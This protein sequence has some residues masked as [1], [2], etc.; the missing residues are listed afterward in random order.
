MK[1]IIIA[2]CVVVIGFYVA[3]GF[4]AS[5]VDEELEASFEKLKSQL[6]KKINSGSEIFDITKEGNVI[7]YHLRF[8]NVSSGGFDVDGFMR[9]AKPQFLR[10]VCSDKLV[11]SMLK[12]DYS[13]QYKI[14]DR[15]DYLLSSFDFDKISCA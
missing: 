4:L 10:N 5:S 8:N 9:S 7:S 12:L 13:F 1:K 6:P 15:D 2:I 11:L 3:K 14:Y